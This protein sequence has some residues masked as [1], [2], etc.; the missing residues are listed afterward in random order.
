M[1]P[2]DEFAKRNQEYGVKLSELT[3]EYYR[4]SEQA[5]S[6]ANKLNE[7]DLSIVEITTAIHINS[8][9]A[10][11]FDAYLAIKENAITLEDIQKGVQL[12][13]KKDSPKGGDK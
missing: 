7:L 1:N 5:K 10:K 12:A 13:S 11:Q 2:G 3:L 6:I 9:A 8:K 4:L